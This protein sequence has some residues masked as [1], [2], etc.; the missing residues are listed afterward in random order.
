MGAARRFT[1]KKARWPTFPSC[2]KVLRVLLP[3]SSLLYSKVEHVY[4][5]LACILHCIHLK[6]L[7]LMLDSK[8]RSHGFLQEFLLKP[9]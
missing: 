3:Q 5:L 1:L 7:G 6:I 4:G 8:Y 9:K 2:L